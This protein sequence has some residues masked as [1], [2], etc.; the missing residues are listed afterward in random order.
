MPIGFSKD[1]P[2]DLHEYLFDG[3]NELLVHEIVD[4]HEAGGRASIEQPHKADIRF[5]QLF[6]L[7][8]G[9]ISV[10]HEGKQHDAQQLL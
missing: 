1:V 7:P 6:D 3:V 8:D 2:V 5:A 10:L 9:N 4:G